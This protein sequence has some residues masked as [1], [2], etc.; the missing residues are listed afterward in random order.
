VDSYLLEPFF[1]V[2][3]AQELD[4]R[5]DEELRAHIELATIDHRL[6]A[7]H[8]AHGDP[9]DS[10]LTVEPL[11]NDW[12]AKKTQ[13]NIWMLLAAVGLVLLIACANVASLLLA[14]GAARR[15]ELA[16]R[17]ALGASRKRIFAQLLIESLTLAV[18]GGSLGVF[19]GWGLMKVSMSMFPELVSSSNEA[20][21][22]MNLPVLGFA[23]LITL[24]A[25]VIFGCAPD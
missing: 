11:H 1:F 19:L 2:V 18:I 20:I 4:A 8:K 16:V 15:Q 10:E 22:E 12:L 6:A 21:V 3:S 7:V 24:L 23:L 9:E 14:R 5:L 25:G 13:Q 17:A